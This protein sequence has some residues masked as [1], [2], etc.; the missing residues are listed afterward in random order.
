MVVLPASI[1]EVGFH[2]FYSVWHV[3]FKGTES[4]WN[5]LYFD[6]TDSSALNRKPVHFNCTGNEFK[7]EVIAA[8]CTVN[9][10]TQYS[11]TVCKEIRQTDPTEAPGHSYGAWYV[12]KEATHASKGL[13][14]RDCN[15]CDHYKSKDIPIQP[16]TDKN[17][18]S[19][20]DGCGSFFCA[21]HKEQTIT[22]TAATCTEDGLTDGKKCSVCNTI[23]QAQDIIP[24]SGHSYDP[25]SKICTLCGEKEQQPEAST[26][27]TTPSWEPIGTMPT[28]QSGAAL[29]D[30]EVK[31]NPI[32][33]VLIVAAAVT[34]IGG[35]TLVL[36]KKKK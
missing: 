33:I 12:A 1:Q 14:R 32:V 2:A 30:E 5:S 16:H 17:N 7:T 8:T 24:A 19:I 20:C 25:E 36:I 21:T 23:L 10:Y 15:N 9:G 6:G 34:V 35:T 22:G 27:A 18:D 13:E 28:T 3:W 11:C 4:Q 31:T 26:P 29:S